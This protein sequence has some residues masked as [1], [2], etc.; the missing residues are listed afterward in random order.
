MRNKNTKPSMKAVKRMLLS[1]YRDG[2]FQ[3]V[4][5][6]LFILSINIQDL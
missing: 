2:H 5:T 1:C 4:V 3:T 6:A